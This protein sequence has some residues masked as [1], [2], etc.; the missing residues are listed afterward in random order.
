[1]QWARRSLWRVGLSA[2]LLGGVATMGVLASPAGAVTTTTTTTTYT[3]ACDEGAW[4]GDVSVK[5]TF[6]YPASVMHGSTFTVQW[7]VVT[8]VTG[9]LASTWY[10]LAG[11]NGYE[12]GTVTQENEASTDATPSPLN[13]AGTQGVPEYGNIS[14]SKSFKVYAPPQGSTPPTVTSTSFT[15]DKAGTDEITPS[16]SVDTAEYY[17]AKG[18][19]VTTDT[20][21]CRPTGTPPVVATITVT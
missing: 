12:E 8:T 19:E 16:S 21:T 9:T 6:T 14:S 4:D 7:K 15:A 17:N 2:T 5:A 1:M 11:P 3:A 13:V 10:A 18:Q 20:A